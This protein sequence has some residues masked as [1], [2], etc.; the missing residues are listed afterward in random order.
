MLISCP[1]DS[2]CERPP[3]G[4]TALHMLVLPWLNVHLGHT[5]Q[6]IARSRRRGGTKSSAS[7]RTSWS[8]ASSSGR[9][10]TDVPKRARTPPGVGRKG[11]EKTR[12]GILVHG[13]ERRVGNAIRRAVRRPERFAQFRG[14]RAVLPFRNDSAHLA[15]RRAPSYAVPFFAPAFRRSFSSIASVTKCMSTMSCV[16]Q[17]SLRRR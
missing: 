8:P 13:Q 16:T 9:P 17:Y 11:R 12:A 7:V 15:G 10:G 2:R 3:A 4:I 6:N 1:R 5:P 14:S